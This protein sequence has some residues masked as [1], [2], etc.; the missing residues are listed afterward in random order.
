LAKLIENEA[1]HMEYNPISSPLGT[2]II[3]FD[4]L[5]KIPDG[6]GGFKPLVPDALKKN[7]G[8]IDENN[9]VTNK[10]FHAIVSKALG[11]MNWDS[12]VKGGGSAK[13]IRFA[14]QN[15]Y[16]QNDWGVEKNGENYIRSGTSLKG[17]P[18]L[19]RKVRDIVEKLGP[20][21]DELDKDFSRR[22]GWTLNREI[23]SGNRRGLTQKAIL[24]AAALAAPLFLGGADKSGAELN[25]GSP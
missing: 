16:G 9:L 8:W 19:Q 7:G 21:I 18:D 15:G 24:P 3:N 13:E 12:G 10:E 14:S 4:H 1:G 20:R 17:R 6:K 11:R 23:N 22:Y 5:I 2:R 25:E